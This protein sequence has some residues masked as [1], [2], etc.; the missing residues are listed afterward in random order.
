MSK[1]EVSVWK[2]SLGFLFQGS[3]LAKETYPNCVLCRPRS[4][5]GRMGGGGGEAGGGRGLNGG[6]GNVSRKLEEQFT[7]FIK[8]N[9]DEKIQIY[10]LCIFHVSCNENLSPFHLAMFRLINVSLSRP[11]R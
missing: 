2:G 9:T 4:R 10:I 3:S 8:C 11:H 1:K 7:V 6:S 5:R